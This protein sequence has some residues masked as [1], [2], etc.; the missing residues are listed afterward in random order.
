MKVFLYKW[1]VWVTFVVL[2]VGCN[3]E[4]PTSRIAVQDF[5]GKPDRSS[6]KV[7][8][9]GSHIAYI[10][11]EDH[12]RNI[13]ILNIN[14]PDSSKQLTQE[15]DMNVQYFFWAT[16]DSIVY[17][18]SH[19]SQDSLR[20]F[21]ID[22]HSE[23][24]NHLIAPTKRNLRWVTPT[25]AYNGE[26]LAQMNQ[27]DS[28]I[29]D[30]YRIPLN[31]SGA[32][33]V[34]TNT[35]NITN[36]MRSPD[37]KVR[38]ALSNDSVESILWYR[39][40]E[41]MPYSNIVQTDYGT[42][43]YP[44]GA[45]GDSK[46]RVFA[47]S[48]RGRDKQA[49]VKLDLQTGDEE[50]ITHDP[51]ADLNFEGYHAVKKDLIFSTSYSSKKI[52]KI[53]DDKLAAL[54][55][56]I[57][58]EFVGKNVDIIDVDSSFQT[59]VFKTYT[60]VNPGTIYYYSAKQ[61]KI[62]ELTAMNPLLEGHNLA[63]ME[64]I[65][66]YSRDGKLIKGY[67]TYPEIKQD[68]YP[69][70]VLVHD[71]PNRRDVWGFNTEVQFL[72]SRGFAVF[73]VNYRGSVG[74]GKEFY[75][76]GF[77]QWGGEIQNDIND[78]VAW[79]I[80]EGIA[81]RDRIAIMGSGFGGYSALYAACFNP[82]LYKCAISASGYTNLFTYF[83]EIPPNYQPYIQLYYQIVGNPI[84]EY[85][86]FKA[87]SPLF[88]AEKVR[89]PILLFHGGKDQHNSLTDV[90]QFVQKVRNNN[91]PIS[92]IYKEEEGKRFRKDE[93]VIEYYNQIERFLKE[94]LH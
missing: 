90:R 75:T 88:H 25:Y 84:K 77:K 55:K 46:N 7:S 31:G 30:L 34:E 48:N 19:S 26:L 4:L 53:H 23:K 33:L 42:S 92:Y 27:R 79:L 67:L 49:I 14:N 52:T 3:Q 18:N 29:F 93:N 64:E 76:A 21:T 16:Q 41:Y 56:K 82:T 20:L 62:V 13:F 73:Q 78:G 2:L 32:R 36:W 22:I 17:V 37:G 60:D 61:D 87:I 63:P 5:F 80:H 91:V 57:C 12:C 6:F 71:G 66:F 45:I 54:Y 59:L 11:I 38:V 15:K 44:F 40:E 8:P 10:G 83:K 89:M 35:G 70:V 47:L 86:L 28:T 1:F 39:A 51:N 58:D 68:K 24:S 50:V 65:S 94:Q 85:E 74:F 9:D 69:V 81:D 43:I 72:A